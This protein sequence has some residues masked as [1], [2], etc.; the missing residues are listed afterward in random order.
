MK[1]SIIGKLLFC[2][3][4]TIT[5]GAYCK[6]NNAAPTAKEP[7]VTTPAFDVKAGLSED[8][9]V[10]PNTTSHTNSDKWLIQNHEKIRL[11]KPRVLVINFANNKTTEE[12]K[13]FVGK[14]VYAMAEGSR[15]HGYKNA[16]AT[17]QLQYIITKFVDLRDAS[18]NAIS[19][20][21]PH[22]ADGSFI[23][24]A[25]FD[26]NFAKY[27]GYKNENNTRYLRLGELFDK[28][29]IND[30]WVIGQNTV[31]EAQGRVRKYDSGFNFTG[32]YDNCQNGCYNFGTQGNTTSVTIRL[33]EINPE[34]GT[35]CATHAFGHGIEHLG[36]NVPYFGKVSERF[37]NFGL[38][39]R[40]DAAFGSQYA[41]PYYVT[42]Q[43]IFKITGQTI[44][45]V[46][47]YLPGWTF[48][49][50]GIGCGNIHFPPNALYHY[51]Y[52]NM[53]KVN[54]NC[55]NFGLRNGINNQDLSAP[56]NYETVKSWNT[57]EYSDCG[58][59]WQIY[60]RQN[61]PGYKS[62]AV[63]NEG[64]PIKS[65]WPFLYY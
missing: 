4:F 12:L 37:F 19:N 6:K 51:D 40:C 64:A 18:G 49:N 38:D 28:G 44:T 30:C 26:D 31:Y 53:Q 34:R 41:A 20:I 47:N 7:K 39:S 25:I 33:N 3:F 48:N 59:E 35:G 45:T 36:Q 60:I 29:I 8:Q 23:Q 5:L 27:L 58:G 50:W 56:Y 11:I 10:W 17:A 1:N 32:D 2:F 61:M 57:P 65:W 16:A 46:N 15:Y 21:R 22:N 42:P 14:V 63:D 43:E 55:E 62:G 52:N 9:G 54:C 24:S 13:M